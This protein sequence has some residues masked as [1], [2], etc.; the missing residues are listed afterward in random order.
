MRPTTPPDACATPLRGKKRSVLMMG[1]LCAHCSLTLLV[2]LLALGLTVAGAYFGLPLV[3]I[4]PP[5]FIGGAFLWLTWPSLR[6][7]WAKLRERPDTTATTG[8]EPQ[9]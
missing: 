1:V 5:I 9:G 8:K 7:S 3:W 4:A 2:P 6:H